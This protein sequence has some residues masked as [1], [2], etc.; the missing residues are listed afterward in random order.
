MKVEPDAAR[1]RCALRNLLLPL[2]HLSTF[3]LGWIGP[4]PG[5]PAAHLRVCLA[6]LPSGPDAVRRL[7]LH[8]VRAAVRPT[9]SRTTDIRQIPSVT[10][11][12]T[13]ASREEPLRELCVELDGVMQLVD[14]D[15][16]L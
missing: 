13:T 11:R 1:D 8:R 14:G 2:F 7:K 6:L 15:V 9:H 4:R 10:Y 5:A 3:P 16:L 12:R